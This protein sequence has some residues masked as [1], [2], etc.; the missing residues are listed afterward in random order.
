MLKAAHPEI[1]LRISAQGGS[2]TTVKGAGWDH[3]LCLSTDLDPSQSKD[4]SEI[5][6]RTHYLNG[7]NGILATGQLFPA[8]RPLGLDREVEQLP[9]GRSY[10]GFLTLGIDGGETATAIHQ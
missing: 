3:H 4:T 9:L 8:Y 5:H 10:P 2:K 6:L 1:S 7:G